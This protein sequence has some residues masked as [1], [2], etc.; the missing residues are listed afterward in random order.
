MTLLHLPPALVILSLGGLLLL[1]A[2]PRPA[3]GPPSGPPPRPGSGG[4]V[5]SRFAA[6]A[7]SFTL[8]SLA[9]TPQFATVAGLHEH[10]DPERG[11]AVDLDREIEDFSPQ[12]TERK[13]RF[14]HAALLTLQ[15]E[16][17]EASLPEQER[18]DRTIIDSQCRLALLDLERLRVAATNPTVAIESIGMALFFPLVLEYAPPGERAA[19]VV[20]RLERVPALVDQAIAALESSTPVFNQ[21]ALEENA[22]NRE[23]IE[24]GLPS[25][26]PKGSPIAG[27]F[28][29]ASREALAALDRLRGFLQKELPAR[30]TGDWRLGPGIYGE[31]FHATFGEDLDPT[32]VLRDAEESLAAARETL[33]SAATP[34]HDAWFPSH[35]GHRLMK[36]SRA[37]TATIVSEVLDRIGRDHPRPDEILEV[38]RRDVRS[39]AE[40]LATRPIVTPTDRDNLKIVETPAFLRGLF[41]VA[42]L[43]PAP[44]L[45]PDLGSFYYVTP[46]PAGLSKA[47][48][49]SRLADYGRTRLL[50]LS[51]HEAIPGHY[52]QFRCANRVLPEWRRI[53]R[54]LYGNGAYVEGWA[55]YAEEMMLEQGFG[56][57]EPQ[58]R[59]EFLQAEM[60]VLANVILDIRLH[61]L[62]MTDQEALSLLKEI[63]RGRA[64]AELKLRRAKI[65]SVQLSSYYVGWRSWRRLRRDVEAA[66]GSSFDLRAFHDEAL[67]QGAI[68]M[69]ALRRLLLGE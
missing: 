50:L 20:A 15:R 57:E 39:I 60:R 44:P 30:P 40:F 36:N 26:V 10:R 5:A 16:F 8:D 45:Q 22:G 51:L 1:T 9:L 24:T 6:F 35:R 55:Q 29:A 2:C 31:K 64:S 42:G 27:S 34:L 18:V 56:G 37:R 48:I 58:V 21:L 47:K 69:V 61:T 63:Y 54:S 43:G 33:Q 25:I 59:I 28:A 7:S 68:P 67:S 66:R 19:D 17:P 49:E 13:I 23:L 12:A 52:L 4:D 3:P 14:Y 11:G 38:V 32:E 53:L 62:G 65:S 46:I 41:N